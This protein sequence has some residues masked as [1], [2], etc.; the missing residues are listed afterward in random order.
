MFALVVS[1]ITLL[2][3]FFL[4]LESKY[5]FWIFG[6]RTQKRKKFQRRGESHWMK[7]WYRGEE[8]PLNKAFDLTHKENIRKPGKYC[9]YFEV[10]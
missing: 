5:N 6:G 4:K 10:V 3:V 8:V 7:L 2:I 9:T 1:Y